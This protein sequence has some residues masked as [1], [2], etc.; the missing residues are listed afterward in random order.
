MQQ[1][2]RNVILYYLLSFLA[3]QQIF[4][5]TASKLTIALVTTN[6][7]PLNQG[8]AGFSTDLAD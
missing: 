2:H 4:A 8:F 7:T 3:V 6:P 1:Q 5:Q